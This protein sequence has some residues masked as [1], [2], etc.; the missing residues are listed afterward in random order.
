MSDTEENVVAEEP[1]VLLARSRFAQG[2]LFRHFFYFF[3]LFD[4]DDDENE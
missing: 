3:L 1:V 4:C 2:S